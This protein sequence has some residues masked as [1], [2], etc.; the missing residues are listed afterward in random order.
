MVPIA[1]SHLL[2]VKR[3]EPMILDRATAHV[4]RQILHHA[5]AMRIALGKADIPLLAGG[6]DQHAA[7]AVVIE[8]G[9]QLQ[10][11]AAPH[12]LKRAQHLAPKQAAHH[13][14]RQQEARAHGLPLALG[15]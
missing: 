9:R 12:V 2:P 8:V 6:G 14:H 4:A 10:L 1:K 5:P 15:L 3:H 11:A 7:H 13:R